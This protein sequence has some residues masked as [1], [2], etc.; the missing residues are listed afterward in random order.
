MRCRRTNT[1]VLVLLIC[2]L[3]ACSQPSKVAKEV[4]GN[5][6]RLDS[7][8]ASRQITAQRLHYRGDPH[9]PWSL[10]SYSEDSPVQVAPAQAHMLQQLLQQPSSYS[11]NSVN[12]CLP[13]YG[14]LLTFRSDSQI[15]RIALCLECNMLGVF[16]GDHPDRVNSKNEF[17]PVRTQLV[18]VAKAIFP[19]DSVI[20]ALK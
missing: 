2:V 11:W 17:D 13:D 19:N 4:F 8:L 7:F 20:Q 18:A 9:N 14:V 10:A 16:D 5:Q 1:G 12:A 3:A 15:V 6:Q